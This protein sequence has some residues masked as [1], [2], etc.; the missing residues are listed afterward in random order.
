MQRF[1]LF[2]GIITLFA[3]KTNTSN[4]SQFDDS[5]R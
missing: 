2:F 1:H 4:I 5:E 3:H